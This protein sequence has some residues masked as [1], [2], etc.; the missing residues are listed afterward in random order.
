[1]GLALPLSISWNRILN[2][3]SESLPV[4]QHAVQSSEMNHWLVRC[5]PNDFDGAIGVASD[6]LRHTSE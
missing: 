1:M 5:R 2:G 4:T 6:C 3:A